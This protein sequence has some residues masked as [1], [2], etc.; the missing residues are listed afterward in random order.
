MQSAI[1]C[2]GNKCI[3]N[4]CNM[5][6]W[7]DVT[8]TGWLPNKSSTDSVAHLSCYRVKSLVSGASNKLSERVNE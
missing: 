1:G 3:G 7:C 5:N 6:D 4:K 2:I 8:V